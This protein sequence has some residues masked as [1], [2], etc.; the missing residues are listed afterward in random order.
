MHK[1]VYGHRHVAMPPTTA[2]DITA[3]PRPVTSGDLM[4]LASYVHDGHEKFGVVTGDSVADLTAASGHDTLASFVGSDDF[5]K[6]D[7]LA[8]QVQG[9]GV[10]L[11][12][13]ELLP[14]IPRPE[15]IV[16]SVR[17]YMD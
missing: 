13:V 15:K 2:A 10:P 9:Q 12:D 3:T 5:D 7:S 17:N 16:C 4:K 11:S 14:V 1:T 8:Q 6:R